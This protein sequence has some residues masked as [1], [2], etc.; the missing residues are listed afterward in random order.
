[1]FVCPTVSKLS[2]IALS[3]FFVFLKESWLLICI[4]LTFIYFKGQQPL[5]L[6]VAYGERGCG[7][8]Q[9]VTATAN[10]VFDR[11]CP[12]VGMA[13]A[14]CKFTAAADGG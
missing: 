11:V 5:W 2:L 3:F 9:F 12:P 1:M 10:G 4:I 6:R 7:C 8:F 13:S 14:K